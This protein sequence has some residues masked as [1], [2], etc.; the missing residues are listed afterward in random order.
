[1]GLTLGDAILAFMNCP[2]PL[3]TLGE[4]RSY[5]PAGSISRFHNPANYTRALRALL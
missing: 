2:H 5:G 3:Q 4:V 1:M